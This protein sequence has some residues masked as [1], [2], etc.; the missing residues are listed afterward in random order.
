MVQNTSQPW[1]YEQDITTSHWMSHQYPT[2]FTSPFGK[3][4]YIKVPFRLTQAPA[5]FQELMRGVL[6]DFSFA[7]AYLDDIV[8]FSRTAEEH[9]YH[10]R[11]VFEKLW[12]AYLSMKLSKW[13]FFTKDI[14]Y[15]GHILNRHE[16]TTIKKI[17]P[18]TTCTHQKQLSRY[19]HS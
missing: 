5:Y 8:I 6:K 19:M 18:S 13:H 9:L 7:T 1:I 16:T 11:Q 12:N 10:I 15:C 14:H 17:M 4:E 2:P 3:Y